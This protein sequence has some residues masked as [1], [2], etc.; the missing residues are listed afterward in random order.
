MEKLEQNPELFSFASL[1]SVNRIF[2]HAKRKPTVK[3]GSF[4]GGSIF[5]MML[6]II[7]EFILNV[8]WG[9]F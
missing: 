2:F 4:N 7:L 1:N 8:F 5:F 6:Q 9:K 3:K